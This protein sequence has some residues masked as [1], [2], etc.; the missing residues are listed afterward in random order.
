M[1]ENFLES[2]TEIAYT[3]KYFKRKLIEYFGNH[4][5]VICS[6]DGNTDIVTLKT[7]AD[8]ILRKYY[9]TPK[10]VNIHHQKFLLLTAAAKLIKADIKSVI[11]DTDK[12]PSLDKL[13][14]DNAI[15]FLPSS[16]YLF[17]H[18]LIVQENDLKAAAIGQAIMQASR[19][20]KMMSPLQVGLCVQLHHHY[21]SR[22]LIDVLNRLGFRSSLMK[23]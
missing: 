12:Y 16:L 15:S 13:D 20:R 22:H 14:I 19:P 17:L 23:Y 9:Q 5:T 18:N 4:S 3:N 10:D 1:M 2:S 11:T 8:S 7:S 21:R 6:E